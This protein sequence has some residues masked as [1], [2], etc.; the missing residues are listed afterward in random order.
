MK[1]ILVIEDEPDVAKSIKLYLEQA[2][3]EVEYTLDAADGLKK[4][5]GFDLILLD[6]IMPK[7]SGRGVLKSMKA[8]GIDKPVVVLSA[9]T[10]P[11]VVSGE[12]VREYPGVVFVPKTSMYSQLIPAIK[13]AIGV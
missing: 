8:K 9:V 4:V 7:L 3:Y 5:K 6:L 11:G 12:L 1:K 2:G 13:K 10:L